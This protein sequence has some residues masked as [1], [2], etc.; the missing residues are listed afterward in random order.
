MHDNPQIAKETG[1]VDDGQGTKKIYRIERKGNTYDMVEL[2]KKHHGQLYG[3]DSYVILYTYLLNGREHYIIYYWLGKKSTT[4][5]KGVAAKKTVEVDDS[6]GGA[7][8]QVRVV[9]GK[10]PNHFLAMFGG[11]LIIFEGGKA[12]WGQSGEEGPGETY[13]LHVRGTNQ[14]NTKAEQVSY[15]RDDLSI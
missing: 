15:S 10:E 12:G 9:H 3:G 11:K 2:E 8:K 14:Y 4:D 6:L 5:E 1:M 13:L 7:A